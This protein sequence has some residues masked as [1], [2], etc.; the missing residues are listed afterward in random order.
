MQPT[1]NR[2][3]GNDVICLYCEKRTDPGNAQKAIISVTS[4][5]GAR[6][7][8]GRFTPIIF[9]NRHFYGQIGPLYERYL[10]VEAPVHRVTVPSP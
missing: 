3:E 5:P 10:G 4:A 2:R 8:L 9:V 7:L 6:M 1:G